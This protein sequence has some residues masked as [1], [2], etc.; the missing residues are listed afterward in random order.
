[1]KGRGLP[2]FQVPREARSV[3]RNPHLTRSCNSQLACL[4]S[5]HTSRSSGCR[6][7]V[8]MQWELRR[9]IGRTTYSATYPALSMP[10][11]APSKTVSYMV[12]WR[13][14]WAWGV[15]GGDGTF[16]LACG[17]WRGRCCRWRGFVRRAVG[18]R[19]SWM[20]RCLPRS[21]T[22]WS[23]AVHGGRCRRASGHRSRLCTAASPS[24]PGPGSG[25]DCTRRFSNSWTSRTW[26]TCPVQSSNQLMSALKGG[27]TCRS[28]PR[29]PG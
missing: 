10:L 29:G 14:C 27:R 7:R 12:S 3:R 6:S 19:A 8:T 24:G 26:S 4:D 18:S 15:V 21:F 2:C 9:S 23:A 22:S 5:C 17:S 28:A 25:A 20:G 11:H 16:R 1:M 13:L